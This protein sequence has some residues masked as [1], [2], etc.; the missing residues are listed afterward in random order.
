RFPLDIVEC[1]DRRIPR[2]GLE[3]AV[4]IT[5][6]CNTELSF[7]IPR[8]EYTKLWHRLLHDRSSNSIVAALDDIPH[9][10]VTIVPYHLGRRRPAGG[11]TPA[12]VPSLGP[13]LVKAAMP[14]PAATHL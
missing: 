1:P 3:L 9:C 14:G 11:S 13:G 12:P 5:E 8:H 6:D 7:L 2:A 10:N 4:H